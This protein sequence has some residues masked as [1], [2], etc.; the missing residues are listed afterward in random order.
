MP[1]EISPD[2]NSYYLVYDLATSKY[3]ANIDG[4][5]TE[6]AL[7]EAPVLQ[8][9]VTYGGLIPT[10]D[11]LGTLTTF[12]LLK[13]VDSIDKPETIPGIKLSIIGNVKPQLFK[14]TKPISITEQYQTGF[15]SVS[16]ALTKLD[17]TTVKV[18]LSY[19]DITWYRYTVAS[20]DGTIPAAWSEVAFTTEDALANGMTLAELAII[21][22]DAFTQLYTEGITKTLY[23]AFVIQSTALDHWT[24]SSIS[25]EFTN[26]K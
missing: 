5:L 10:A 23:I 3:Y 13:C 24:L 19:D 16:L 17:T 7:Q 1:T 18:L 15:K 8:D 4:S 6:V 20:S 25:V 12:E 21:D 26:T 14:C 22:A 9:F 2:Y 11:M